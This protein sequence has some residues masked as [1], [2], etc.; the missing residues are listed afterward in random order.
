MKTAG[1]QGVRRGRRFVT[2]K[3]DKAAVRPPLL[4]AHGDGQALAGNV[5]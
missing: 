1:L 4:T 5:L 2:T 3:A